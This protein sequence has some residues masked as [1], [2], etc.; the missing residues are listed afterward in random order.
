MTVNEITPS[1]CF[2]GLDANGWLTYPNR[3]FCPKCNYGIYFNQ[4]SLSKGFASHQDKTSRL[5]VDDVLVFS[6][7]IEEFHQKKYDRFI[8]DFY[9]PK[10]HSPYIIGFEWTEFHMADSR[11]R[12]LVVFT[13]SESNK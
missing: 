12:P 7:S 1:E 3:F 11:F 5:K 10:C 4:Q 6:E 8:L 13:T 9:C 2:D